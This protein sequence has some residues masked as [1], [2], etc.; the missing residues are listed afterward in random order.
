MAS[1]SEEKAITS[2]PS[3]LPAVGSI[4]AD[5]SFSD[6]YKVEWKYKDWATNNQNRARVEKTWSRFHTYGTGGTK[7]KSHKR[8]LSITAKFLDDDVGYSGARKIPKSATAVYTRDPNAKN[9]TAYVR[10]INHPVS[11]TS[12]SWKL[13]FKYWYPYSYKYYTIDNYSGGKV[14]AKKRN[15]VVTDDGYYIRVTTEKKTVNGKTTT[16]KVYTKT[17]TW[18]KKWKYLTTDKKSSTDVTLTSSLV[19]KYGTVHS[20]PFPKLS[21]LIYK[22]WSGNSKGWSADTTS[23]SKYQFAPPNKPALTDIYLEK[24]N[25]AYTGLFAVDITAAETQTIDNQ[26]GY[27]EKRRVAT[28]YTLSYRKRSNDGV[29]TETSAS[30]KKGDT[31]WNE[32]GWVITAQNPIKDKNIAYQPSDSSTPPLDPTTSENDFITNDEFTVKSP[33]MNSIFALTRGEWIEVQI[34]AYSMGPAGDSDT[35]KKTRRIGQPGMVG[36]KEISVDKANQAADYVLIVPD[37]SDPDA[38][39]EAEGNDYKKDWSCYP[40]E[41][42]TLQRLRN[43]NAANATI[44]SQETGWVD[45]GGQTFANSNPAAQPTVKGFR[46]AYADAVSD[47]NT[48]TWYRIKTTC[49]PFEPRYGVPKRA[50]ALFIKTQP[51]PQQD[52]E[53]RIY[54]MKILD[55]GEI[56]F[57]I[58]FKEDDSDRTEVSWSPKERSWKSNQTPNTFPVTWEDTTPEAGIPSGYTKSSTM[59]LD[60]LEEGVPVYIKARRGDGTNY[61]PYAEPPTGYFP[62]TP[63]TSPN[64]V[65]LILPDFVKRGED[66][67]IQWVYDSDT[68]AEQTQWRLYLKDGDSSRL[69]NNGTDAAGSTIFS[70]S[71]PQIWN[72]SSLEFYVDV[73]TGGDFKSSP[74]A[75]VSIADPPKVSAEVLSDVVSAQ[76]LSIRIASS[77]QNIGVILKVIACGCTY[78]RPDK[79]DILSNGE[80]IYSKYYT[81][82][83]ERQNLSQLGFMENAVTFQKPGIA[84]VSLAQ[85]KES[86]NSIFSAIF[87]IFSSLSNN[88]DYGKELLSDIYY[89][90]YNAEVDDD[91]MLTWSG[92][93][94]LPENGI[95]PSFMNIE[96]LYTTVVVPAGSNDLDF[97]VTL[98]DGYGLTTDAFTQLVSSLKWYERRDSFSVNPVVPSGFSYTYSIV[99][100][101]LVRYTITN[102]SG[103]DLIMSLVKLPSGKTVP[104]PPSPAD[105]ELKVQDVLASFSI[106]D[107]AETPLNGSFMI[108]ESGGLSPEE[109]DFH[110]YKVEVTYNADGTVQSYPSYSDP[111]AWLDVTFSTDMSESPDATGTGSDTEVDYSDISDLIE[112]TYDVSS[113]SGGT[114]VNWTANVTPQTVISNNTTFV[115]VRKEPDRTGMSDQ[116]I[117]DEEE[118]IMVYSSASQ[119]TAEVTLP[120]LEKLYDMGRYFLYTSAIDLAT[121]LQSETNISSIFDVQYAHQAVA[122][123]ED[124]T[125]V[126]DISTKTVAITPVANNEVHFPTDVVDIYRVTPNGASL[127]AEDVPFGTE[128][129]D[130]YAPFT[131]ED[132]DL[133]Y[134]LCTRTTDG[135]INWND[136]PYDMHGYCIRFDW[137]DNKFIELPYNI[138]VKDSYSKDVSI[139]KHLDGT[140]AAY[141]NAG[142]TRTSSLSTK[143]VRIG[144]AAE[145]E[146]VMD[147]AQETGP[148]MV[149][150]PSGAA[151]EANVEVKNY[152]MSFDTP[153][154][155]VS[156]EATELTPTDAYRIA[157]AAS[158]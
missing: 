11:D 101:P 125:V 113:E 102:T 82:R 109:F 99:S 148:V 118:T 75:S 87:G 133:R 84:E 50:D 116:D 96:H 17:A 62:I 104:D 95:N 2:V 56:Q 128:V 43:S 121:G 126:P 34:E 67:E 90:T 154:I 111:P 59:V 73:S 20:Q 100:V 98:Q 117:A 91:G 135:D 130:K 49:E 45:V 48:Y 7:N 9:T 38:G 106:S 115:I 8:D 32:S 153:V 81:G 152:N 132:A 147:L 103:V 78:P 21:Y 157:V 89:E 144:A 158:S 76:S 28:G 85:T 63:V 42:V 47:T 51:A 30:H 88:A 74:A 55:H 69:I 70:S 156:F 24:E 110:I 33:Q 65:E 108:N 31:K 150:T 145:K 119:Y 52:D 60:G 26:K 19:K 68:G 61:G 131:N 13:N 149:R 140:N 35:V 36:V 120:F 39:F 114:L 77:T 97:W 10:D 1:S 53:C 14:Q 25:N 57:S 123:S 23:S 83:S 94:A 124:S 6:A 72:K 54:G 142:V 112:E 146:L 27:T 46:D 141:W 3:A 15:L 136:I 143:M 139:R 44:A 79:T 37:Y 41:T 127:I 71:D 86:G 64:S 66:F 29:Y 122:P 16:K 134:R 12:A 138:A 129:V 137:G 151:Y 92:G 40:T 5:G 80:V 93:L 155:E 18:N 107:E 22:I 105:N 4:K 58:A